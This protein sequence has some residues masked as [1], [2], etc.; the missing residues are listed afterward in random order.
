M[1]RLI[2]TLVGRAAERESIFPV[3][4][5]HHCR[6]LTSMGTGTVMGLEGRPVFTRPT[7]LWKHLERLRAY[8][9]ARWAQQQKARMAKRQAKTK[10]TAGKPADRQP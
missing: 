10:G 8:G 2:V 9:E 7:A 4:M 5:T 6:S 1:L 3:R